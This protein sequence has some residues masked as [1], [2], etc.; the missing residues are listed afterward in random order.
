MKCVNKII[1]SK[2]RN[3]LVGQRPKKIGIY[4]GTFDPVH[5]GHITFALEAAKQAGVEIVYFLPDL[6][7]HRK[8]GVTHYA[9]RTAML[10]LALRPY[11]ALRVL[12][13]ADKQFT[14]TRTLP[15]L[16]RLFP[17]DELHLLMGTDVLQS[18]REGHWPH[19]ERLLAEVRL[20]V[21]V[22]AQADLRRAQQI[23]ATIQ[24]H[25][26]AIET[27]RPAASSRAIRNALQDGKTHHELLE[28]I[29]K[30]ITE[31]WLYVTVESVAPANNS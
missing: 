6:V 2:G 21:G 10:K 4:S 26:L 30:Y 12:E 16:K 27:G 20:V 22:R 8:E 18:L 29:K 19:A 15:K 3:Q 13:L 24:P 31:N 11:P 7:P 25:G 1:K 28:S 9:H 14:I 23:L 17:H 5:K